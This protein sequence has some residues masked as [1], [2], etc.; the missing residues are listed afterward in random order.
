MTAVPNWMAQASMLLLLFT[1]LDSCQGHAGAVDFIEPIHIGEATC[2]S[3]AEG[4]MPDLGRLVLRTDPALH[5]S[6]N[7]IKGM[8]YG[9]SIA[10]PNDLVA[11]RVGCLGIL[12]RRPFLVLDF[13]TGMYVLDA[14]G[15]GCADGAGML[16]DGEI[17]PVEFLPAISPIQAM[18]A[19]A[20]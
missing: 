11:F 12:A 18:C 15:D 1:L 17:D 3:R 2:R 9:R 10:G 19:P 4:T 20:F 16:P 8:Y 5:A 14:D 13:R 7:V 6:G